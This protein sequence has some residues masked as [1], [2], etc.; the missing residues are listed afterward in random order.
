MSRF[1]LVARSRATPRAGC[2][3][4][5]VSATRGQAGQIR[6]ANLA[7]RKNPRP[8]SRGGAARWL[9]HE[10]A[11]NMS[12]AGTTST[13]CWPRSTDRSWRLASARTIRTYRPDVVFTFGIEGAYGHPDH[14]AISRATTAACL[15]RR[16]RRI[17]SAALYHA[18]SRRD[19]V[20][21]RITWSGG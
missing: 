5:V 4:M 18:L 3:I 20:C 6:S 13:G 21:Y 7:T 16:K 9:A 12:S 8:G 17:R 2:D 1:A 10:L 11:S 14:I 15:R 19:A